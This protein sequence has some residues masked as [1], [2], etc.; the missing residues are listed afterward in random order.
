MSLCFQKISACNET[1][2]SNV[3]DSVVF[4][5]NTDQ[6]LETFV[7]NYKNNPSL[8]DSLLVCLLKC[9]M[10]KQLG[11]RNPQLPEIA[12]N[13]FI[14]LEATNRNACSL[15]SGALN[16]PALRSIQRTNSKTRSPPFILCDE[17][18][19]ERKVRSLVETMI[20]PATKNQGAVSLIFD[21][22]KLPKVLQVSSTHKA[23]IG[24]AFPNVQL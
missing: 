18:N 12:M 9:A 15:V 24:G 1:K 6:F 4:T 13:F 22:T 2:V 21:G 19:L 23:I 10:A 20:D 3:T 11:H 16:G 17:I 7:N 14:S 8:R 5:T